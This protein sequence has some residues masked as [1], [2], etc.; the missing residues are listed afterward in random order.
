MKMMTFMVEHKHGSI[1]AHKV[2]FGRAKAAMS[3]H[4]LNHTLVWERANSVRNQARLFFT[5]LEVFPLTV[6]G[7]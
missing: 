7:F 5:D 4:W 1:P 6:S 2:L 3:S